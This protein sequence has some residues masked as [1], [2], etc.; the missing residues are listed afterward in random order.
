MAPPAARPGKCLTIFF[1]FFFFEETKLQPRASGSPAFGGSPGV[2][3]RCVGFSGQ[4]CREGGLQPPWERFWAPEPTPTLR[5]PQGP[6]VALYFVVFCG[7]FGSS[8]GAVGTFS[9]SSQVCPREAER[10]GGSPG[11]SMAIRAVPTALHLAQNQDLGLVAAGGGSSA[12]SQP[13]PWPGTEVPPRGPEGGFLGEGMDQRLRWLV[14]CAWLLAPRCREWPTGGAR[15]CPA[16]LGPTPE[17]SGGPR[18][19]QRN[20]GR[21]QTSSA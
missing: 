7:R 20:D 11:R 19:L 3:A 10:E 17:H 4:G 6:R 21:R 15:T 14:L 8:G 2:G 9:E 18:S 16:H 5:G 13:R 12:C 1:F